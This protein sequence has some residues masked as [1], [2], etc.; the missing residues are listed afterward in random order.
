MVCE[1]WGAGRASWVRGWSAGWG[2]LTSYN[3]TRDVSI[4]ALNSRCRKSGEAGF[5]LAR[6]YNIIVRAGLHCAPLVHDRIDGGAG[7]VRLSLSYFTTDA[8]CERTG[9]VLREV[10][11]SADS[12]VASA[13]VL[14]GRL[15]YEGG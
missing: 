4:M 15:V 12:A 3:R 8:E 5:V 6:G 9:A 2:G 7:C 14:G 1:E 11:R 10:M 13:Y